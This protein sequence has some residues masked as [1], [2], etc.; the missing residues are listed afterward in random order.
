MTDNEELYSKR[1]E[2]EIAIRSGKLTELSYIIALL[3]LASLLTIPNI[4]TLY[5]SFIS[6]F[7]QILYYFGLVITLGLTFYTIYISFLKK[8]VLKDII[9]KLEDYKLNLQKEKETLL[10]L[11]PMVYSPLEFETMKKERRNFIMT[12]EEEGIEIYDA[13]K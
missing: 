8:Y 9:L 11:E 3:A 1:A 13:R 5:P 4:P 7:G 6:E 12:I 2:T 10:T